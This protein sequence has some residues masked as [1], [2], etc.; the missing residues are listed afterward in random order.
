MT[1][2]DSVESAGRSETVNETRLDI[3]D[4]LDSC[5][6]QAFTVQVMI[7]SDIFGDNSSPVSG[8]SG[9]YIIFFSSISI[10]KTHFH[11]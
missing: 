8:F 10:I 11:D 9:E 1:D 6:R 5:R 3:S 4:M 2:R 7:N